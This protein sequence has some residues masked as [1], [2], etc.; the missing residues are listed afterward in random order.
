MRTALVLFTDYSF[1]KYFCLFVGTA[2]G[3]RRTEIGV[4]SLRY[5]RLCGRVR[6]D[7]AVSL[8]ST[9]LP[10]ESIQSRYANYTGYTP[11]SMTHAVRP[12]TFHTRPGP[13]GYPKAATVPRADEQ[14]PS[15]IYAMTCGD[16]SLQTLPPDTQA[17][18]AARSRTHQAGR[19]HCGC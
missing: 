16:I 18:Q 15:S 6:V 1:I 7:R 13:L 10:C 2:H 3:S 12:Y 19:H 14:A 11:R 17:Q 4:S 5:C 8:R 9:V